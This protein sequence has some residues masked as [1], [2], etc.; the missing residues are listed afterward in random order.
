MLGGVVLVE[1]QEDF[2]P[3]TALGELASGLPLLVAP[4]WIG[5]MSEQE[6]DHVHVSRLGGEN[7]CRRTLRAPRVW[8]CAALEQR[9]T[10]GRA[11][12]SGCDEERRVA[13][14]V[15]LV[16]RRAVSKQ[17]S[18]DRCVSEPCRTHHRRFVVSATGAR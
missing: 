6:S 14:R 10:S 18:D 4:L 16:D 17:G 1:C 9:A 2:L 8:I 12:L 5:A 7:Q 3:A 15:R 11:S 13:S